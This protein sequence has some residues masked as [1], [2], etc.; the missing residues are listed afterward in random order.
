MKRILAALLALI[1]I[2]STLALTSCGKNDGAP[3]GMQ[4]VRGGAD[5]GYNFWGP[6]EWVVANV[7]DISCT[8][9]SKIDMSS[10]PPRLH[11]LQNPQK[12]PHRSRQADRH[13]RYRRNG[14]HLLPRDQRYHY[15]HG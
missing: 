14:S 4:L 7:G 10:M 12:A 9:A 8:Y 5:V 6:E 2:F 3:D 1:A 11:H 13:Q 15:Q